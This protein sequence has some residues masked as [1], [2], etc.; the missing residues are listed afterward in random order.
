MSTVVKDLG[1]VSAYAYAVEK[2]YTGTEAEFAEL[3]ADYA[4]VGQRAEDAAD[5]A[6]ESKTAA[7]TAATTA[8]NK[9]SEATTAA[10]T[11][12]TKAS[13]ASTSASQA[14][15]SAT[16]ASTKASEASQSASTASAKATEATTAATSANTA[17]VDA[18]AAKTAAET[19]QGKAEDAQAAAEAVAES[20]PSDYSQLSEDV[21]DIKENLDELESD[22]VAPTSK[23]ML[24]DNY[25]VDSVPYHFRKTASDNADREELEIVGGSVAWNQLCYNGDLASSTEWSAQLGTLSI[26]NGV[27]TLTKT[28]ADSAVALRRSGASYPDANGTRSL[29]GHVYYASAF[30]K[31]PKDTAGSFYIFNAQSNNISL[32]ANVEKHIG[33]I[34]KLVSASDNGL[35]VYYDRLNVMSVDESAT[36]RN[37]M[38]IDLTA[39]FGT[40]IADHIYSLEQAT[41]GAG[42]AFFKSLFP[43]DYYPYNAGELLSVSGLSEHRTVGFN[44]WDEEWENGNIDTNTGQNNSNGVFIRSSDYIPC[45]PDTEYYAF[46]RLSR[47]VVLYFYDES[48]NYLGFVVATNAVKRTPINACY[49]RLRYDIEALVYNKGTICINFSDPVKNGTYEPYDG[50]SYAL[51]DSLTLRGVPTL[52][53]GKIKWD[54]DVYSPS[55]KVTRRYGIVDL[56]T[57]TWYA[58]GATDT[59]DRYITSG[60]DNLIAYSA[61]HITAICHKY[62]SVL[63]SDTH[64]ANTLW[65]GYGSSKLTITTSVG[66]YASA[67][68]FKTAMNGVYLVY[69]KATPTT[70]TADPYVSPQICHYD[71]TEEFVSTGIVP[72]GH[73][74][75]YPDNMRAKLDGLP[76]NFANLIAPVEKTFTATRNYTT[77]ALLIVNNV[78][79]KATANIANGGTIT[80][81]TNV[82]ATTLAEVIAALA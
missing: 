72:I 14:S 9:A 67:T 82:T 13:E 5:S 50:H 20:I 71:G 34:V 23:Q 53:D 60:L 22:G 19:A 46:S 65:V 37:V 56:G 6:L 40:T 39:M 66:E 61:N 42:V 80:V 18:V 55:G 8:T 70:E 11:A 7:Q 47:Q 35:N 75:K 4:E 45:F 31:S 28:S 44:Q 68:A 78:L 73:N 21:S 26:A 30:V 77:G 17:K 43:N 29:I 58:Y 12:T 81:G 16:T 76:W 41:A 24:S 36:I 27:A 64:T 51:D 62:T 33:G 2:G 10:Q 63:V 1:A 25:S 69:E 48:K 15:A 49:M 54:G 57:L 59:Y 38:L 32:S 79:Y 74:T 3:M 52:V